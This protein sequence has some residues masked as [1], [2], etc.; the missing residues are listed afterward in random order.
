MV[1][2]MMGSR[3]GKGGHAPKDKQANGPPAFHPWQIPS[4]VFLC[5]KFA[6][7]LTFFCSL[8]VLVTFIDLFLV[9]CVTQRCRSLLR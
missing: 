3:A 9:S 2:P 4:T 1:F 8:Y 6:I 7:Q 5:Y